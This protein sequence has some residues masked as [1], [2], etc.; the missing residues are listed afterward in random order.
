MDRLETRQEKLEAKLETTQQELNERIDK[1][2][3]KINSSMKDSQILAG[4]CL[5]ITIAVL[6]ALFLK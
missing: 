4:S 3:D 1:L 6:P 2:A 5:I